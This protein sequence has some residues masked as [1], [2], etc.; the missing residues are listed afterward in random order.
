[1]SSPT[2]PC[3]RRCPPPGAWAGSTPP[4]AGPSR[5]AWT[6]T[7]ALKLDRYDYLA[8]P[9]L[10]SGNVGLRL[11]VAPRTSILVSASPHMT[12]PG[13]E[14]FLPPATAGMWLP[15]ERTFS[16]FDAG[17]A[18]RPERTNRYDVQLETR[19]SG[20]AGGG[21]VVRIGRFA[22]MTADQMATLFGLDAASASGHY[23][24][25]APGSVRVEG[26]VVGFAGPIAR[27]VQ[28]TI[29]YRNTRGDWT[30]ERSTA[31]LVRLVPSLARAGQ[32]AAHDLTTSLDAIVP[33]TSTEVTV[34]YRFNTS[35]S[36]L[37]VLQPVPV[38]RFKVEVRQQLPFQ[39]LG[40]GEL[41]LL[42]SAR[43]MLNE[44][45]AGA[46]YDELLTVAPPLRVTCGL[47]MRF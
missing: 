33:M 41:N 24:V 21:A 29:D 47:Q 6:S 36:E 44:P 12:A 30:A 37:L 32:D 9:N 35:V 13:A 11:A 2:R 17:E 25:T 16:A 20:D 40:R 10:V 46:Y 22:E 31:D 5:T 45:G 39:P 23:Y 3:R 18:L 7:T 1:M 15:P 27:H 38:G 43:T 19:V 28:G 34:A 14:Q 26:W 4:I 8:D 42:F